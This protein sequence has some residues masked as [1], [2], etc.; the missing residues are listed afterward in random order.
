MKYL[1]HDQ[2]KG[3][4]LYQ[5][6][7]RKKL[8]QRELRQAVR[9]EQERIQYNMSK[10]RQALPHLTHLSLTELT[11]VHTFLIKTQ[12]HILIFSYLTSSATIIAMYLGLPQDGASIMFDDYCLRHSILYFPKKPETTQFCGFYCI[13]L[14]AFVLLNIFTV[15][16]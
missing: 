9:R 11:L 13:L 6:R 15:I 4:E 3:E 16:M 10:D 5:I 12:V 2:T 1:F 8:K 14:K 7:S